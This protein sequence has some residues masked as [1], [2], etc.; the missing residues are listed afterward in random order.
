M[1][2]TWYTTNATAAVKEDVLD[3]IILLQPYDRPLL[4]EF[5]KTSATQPLHTWLKDAYV[6]P[7]SNAHVEGAD[8]TASDFA[9]PTRSSN[10]CQI[11]SKTFAISETMKATDEYGDANKVSRQKRKH[12]EELAND[13]EYS[14][15]AQTSASGAAGTAR[16]MTG[17]LAAITSHA[18]AYSTAA[19]LTAADTG[20]EQAYL[21]VCQAV[22]A[23]GGKPSWA[24]GS[25]FSKRRM[26]TWSGTADKWILADDKSVTN[27]VDVYRS[28]FGV[29]KLLASLTW[30]SVSPTTV[31]ILTPDKWN[32][33]RLRPTRV[34][35][36][37]IGGDSDKYQAT[38]ELTLEFLAEEA[39]GK[40]TGLASTG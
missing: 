22:F 34:R 33:A 31:A 15:I 36:L 8:A 19:V 18:S 4:A 26:S 38:A 39:N 10:Y 14:L 37:G 21:N 9:N 35:Q 17:V 16:R 3:R 27:V 23:S 32:I 7:A 12:M 29:Q 40:L 13:I 6:A 28:P 2:N 11:F 25:L 30:S 5:G 20:F 24:I 1:P